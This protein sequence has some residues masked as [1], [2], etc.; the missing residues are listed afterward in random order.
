MP[1]SA[2]PGLVEELLDTEDN[3]DRE[4]DAEKKQKVDKIKYGLMTRMLKSY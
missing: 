2:I 1:F 3:L 4:A